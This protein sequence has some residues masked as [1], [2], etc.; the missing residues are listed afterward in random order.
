MRTRAL[1][2]V[3]DDQPAVRNM[4]AALLRRRGHEV[5]EAADGEQAIQAAIARPPDLIVM[6]VR[7]PR[8][9]GIESLRRMRQRPA[10]RRT[11]A[12]VVSAL[13][14]RAKVID[15][16]RCGASAFFLKSRFNIGEFL[17][18]VEAML[19][20]QQG[21]DCRPA[22]AD[23]PPMVRPVGMGRASD[24]RDAATMPELAHRVPP[25]SPT[26]LAK[27][28]EAIAHVRLLPH[29][30]PQ[31]MALTASPRSTASQLVAAV[32]QDVALTAKVLA[33][34]N[35]CAFR[36]DHTPMIDLTTAVRNI[37]FG[38]VRQA[39][40]SLGLAQMFT[41]E[42]RTRVFDRMKFW[43]HS[44]AAATI[45]RAL[46]RRAGMDDALAFTIGLLHGFGRL[47]QEDAF[48]A[49]LARLAEF[50]DSDRALPA[51]LER[52]WMGLEHPRL[53][54]AVMRQWH[55]PAE[56]CGPIEEQDLPLAALRNKPEP[57]RRWAALT[58][59]ANHLATCFGFGDSRL[60]RIS[61][62]GDELVDDFG[63]DDALLQSLRGTLPEQVRD[64]KMVMLAYAPPVPSFDP[65]E[66]AD[67]LRVLYLRP[68]AVHLDLIELYLRLRH[69]EFHAFTDAGAF[70]AAA[71]A[72][73]GAVRVVVNLLPSPRVE[74]ALAELDAWAG[75]FDR[76]ECIEGLLLARPDQAEQLVGP[77]E[78]A[79]RGLLSP[80][81]VRQLERFLGHEKSPA[82]QGSC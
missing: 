13:G 70:A 66:P 22:A 7:M 62:I 52:R 11:P 55:I 53:A 24:L 16:V 39:A 3:A 10:L 45:A 18:K 82:F 6:D 46:A 38:S 42:P 32:E 14:T 44:F 60:L 51:D 75:R 41:D 69:P 68:R 28:V 33:I 54:A 4:L 21:R 1:I 48:A 56:I 23:G 81:S 57:Q 77:L 79:F 47:L 65:A 78:R 64:M 58:R 71:Q 12:I 74:R 43:E 20:A 40:L 15:A 17:A 49:D 73:T 67:R 61:H 31:I 29:V 59:L 9:G 30:M 5:I 76:I 37:G 19:A 27:Q 8:L 35:S 2:L 80:V 72:A 50:H 63:I 34:A 26:R 36:R 25:V